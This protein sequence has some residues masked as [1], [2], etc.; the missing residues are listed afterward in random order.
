[1]TTTI[2]VST[3]TRNT[4]NSLAKKKGISV[5]DAAR[6]AVET[7]RRQQLLEVANAAYAKLRSNPKDAKAF[8]DET[9]LWDATLADGLTEK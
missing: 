5:Q 1:M 4:L 6:E 7:Y 2:R 8:D 9:K 3:E